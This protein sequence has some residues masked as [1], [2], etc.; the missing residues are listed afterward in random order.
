MRS[1][2]AARKV[3]VGTLVSRSPSRG[4]FADHN[5]RSPEW[6]LFVVCL[7]AVAHDCNLCGRVISRGLLD[8]VQ[9]ARCE[10]CG[11]KRHAVVDAR[12]VLRYRT[13]R[14]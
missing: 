2:Q 3:G 8:I 7:L 11:V 4:A 6:V 10:R 14:R 13:E 9:V 1:W 12:R 5:E